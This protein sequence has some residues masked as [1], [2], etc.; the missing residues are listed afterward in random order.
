MSHFAAT[1]LYRSFSYGCARQRISNAIFD[2][3]NLSGSSAAD[4]GSDNGSDSDSSSS[5]GGGGRR[6]TT[7]KTK[8]ARLSA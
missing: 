1:N 5:K 8:P 7:R 6:V 4:N 2:H 3:R